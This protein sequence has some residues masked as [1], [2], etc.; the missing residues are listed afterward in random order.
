M[1][2]PE[3]ERLFADYIRALRAAHEASESWV[4]MGGYGSQEQIAFVL[5]RGTLEDARE[6]LIARYPSAADGY[7]EPWREAGW[8]HAG[9]FKEHLYAGCEFIG[10]IRCEDL[11]VRWYLNSGDDYWFPSPDMHPTIPSAEKACDEAA[12]AWVL[13]LLAKRAA[14]WVVEDG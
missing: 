3:Y 10:K 9:Y 13:I 8:A 6:A 4:R 11:P 7:D 5:S 1:N 2:D 12:V 14:R